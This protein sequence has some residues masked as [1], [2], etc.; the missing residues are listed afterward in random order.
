M[1]A[2]RMEGGS[3]SD[4]AGLCVWRQPGGGGP[5]GG[6]VTDTGSAGLSCLTASEGGLKRRQG[7]RRERDSPLLCGYKHSSTGAHALS[8]WLRG[9][10][11]ALLICFSQPVSDG[12]AMVRRQA[13]VLQT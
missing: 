5:V 6:V 7:C 12:E 13:R 3:Y 2:D 1:V 8:L 9:C 4:S 10:W 11:G